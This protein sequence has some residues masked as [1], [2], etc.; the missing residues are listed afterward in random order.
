MIEQVLALG[1]QQSFYPESPNHFP[2]DYD[3]SAVLERF[4]EA[5]ISHQLD[6]T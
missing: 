5:A 4:R 6:L 2:V 3:W 1:Q